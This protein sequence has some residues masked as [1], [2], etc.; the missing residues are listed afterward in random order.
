[1][2]HVNI[3]SPG[4]M[5]EIH[6]DAA[7]GILEGEDLT[8]CMINLSRRDKEDFF[9][10]RGTDRYHRNVQITSGALRSGVLGRQP[11]ETMK[12]VYLDAEP[13]IIEDWN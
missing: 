2:K 1:M 5:V 13:M 7:L 8:P 12:V 10:H 6:I 9:N 4:A 11:L 3:T